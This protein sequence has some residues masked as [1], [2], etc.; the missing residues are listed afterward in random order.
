LSVRDVM[1]AVAAAGL[2]LKVSMTE[3]ILRAYPAARLTEVLAAA[4]KEHKADIIQIM[5]EDELMRHT[6]VI[7]SERQVIE[8]SRE[9]FGLNTLEGI[10]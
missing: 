8:M 7:Q 3:D 5:R 4:I 1:F 6:G 2:T 9:Y 10:A